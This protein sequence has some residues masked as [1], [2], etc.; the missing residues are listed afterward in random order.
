MC[1]ECA[2]LNEWVKE[3]HSI[4]HKPVPINCT[5]GQLGEALEKTGQKYVPNKGICKQLGENV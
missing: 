5:C 1:P 4:R 2:Y 3:T